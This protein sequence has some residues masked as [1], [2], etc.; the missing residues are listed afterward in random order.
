MKLSINNIG[1]LG[2]A[3]IEINGIT[4]IAGENN[5]GKSTVGKTLY[6]LFSA[7]HNI[8]DKITEE[9]KMSIYRAISNPIRRRIRVNTSGLHKICDDI[10]E[11][12]DIYVNDHAL[13]R[14]LIEE[15]F[16]P[17]AKESKGIE[18]INVDAIY[19][20]VLSYLKLDEDSIKAL[21]LQKILSSEYGTQIGHVNRKDSLSSVSLDIHGEKSIDVELKGIDGINVINSIDM[22]SNIPYIED[23]FAVDELNNDMPMLVFRSENHRSKLLEMLVQKRS[24]S[25]VSNVIEEMVVSEKLAA[26]FNMLNNICEG[27]LERPSDKYVYS[28][29]KYDEPLAL[30]NISTGLKTF[31]ILKTLLMN[32]AIE[33]GG[34]IILDEPEIHLHPE[35]QL[36]FAELIVL[37]QKE[38]G[39]HILLNTHSPYF[40][41]ALQVYS[42][43][44]QI[45]DSC[46]YYLADNIGDTAIIADVSDNIEKIYAKLSRPLQRLEDMRWQDDKTE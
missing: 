34:T 19:N 18:E 6:C 36:V 22:Y 42:A 20:R 26:I 32:G 2:E 11:N 9:R 21:V 1:K 7:F 37:I 29:V 28:S 35:W 45:A 27:D 12:R 15:I 23:P 46:K 38:F 41:R 14:S 5:T 4:V 17:F 44:Y 39:V 13:L 33:E 25:T 31:L 30:S 43:K 24:R 10:C 3:C 16:A 8:N 40:L